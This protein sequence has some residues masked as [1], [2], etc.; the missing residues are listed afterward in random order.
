MDPNFLIQQTISLE[1]QIVGLTR[2]T[3]EWERTIQGLLYLNLMGAGRRVDCEVRYPGSTQQSADMVVLE[4]H[5]RMIV[6]EMKVES[7]RNPGIFSDQEVF[8]SV[9]SDITKLMSFDTRNSRGLLRQPVSGRWCLVIAITSRTIAVLQAS[10]HGDH[11]ALQSLYDDWRP[12]ARERRV[13]AAL[14]YARPS[15]FRR[16]KTIGVALFAYPA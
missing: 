11:A 13:S 8:A 10:Y 15:H 7:V 1:N 14:D 4:D 6:I 12:D 3:L 16:G 5:Q 2:T 9:E